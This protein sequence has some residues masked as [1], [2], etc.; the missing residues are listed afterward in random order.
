MLWEALYRARPW[1]MDALADALTR[2]FV[3]AARREDR[4]R[5][6][7]VS[8]A[9]AALILALAWPVIRWSSHWLQYFDL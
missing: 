4:R 7:S 8:V 1:L 2:V 3:E 5:L 6:L 9:V